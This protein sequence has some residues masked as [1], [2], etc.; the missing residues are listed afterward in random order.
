MN[1]MRVASIVILSLVASRT[2][3]QDSVVPIVGGQLPQ[4]LPVKVVD[5]NGNPIKG[6]EVSPWAL[7]SSQGHG[8]WANNGNDPSE[9]NPAAVT[10]NSDGIAKVIY[11]F[12]RDV[13]EQTRTT[14]VSLFLKH[15]EYSIEDSVHLDVPIA[16]DTPEIIQM[17]LSASIRFLPT[18]DG[19]P[20]RPSEIQV[21]RSD[22]SSFTD[23]YARHI[24]DEHVIVRRLAPEQCDF[25][26]VR[27]VDEQPTHFSEI[28]TVDL[29]SGANDPQVVELAPSTSLSG[30]I[31]DQVPRPIREGRVLAMTVP[32][33]SNRNRLTWSTWG[34]IRTDGTFEIPHWPKGETMQLIGLT[35][36][37]RIRS[38]MV[39]AQGRKLPNQAAPAE[40]SPVVI[41]PPFTHPIELDTEQLHRCEIRLVD[42][43][44]RPVAGA[45]V[46]AYPNVYWKNWGSQLYGLPLMQS[47]EFFGNAKLMEEIN[48]QL[49]NPAFPNR[50]MGPVNEEGEVELRL[51]SGEWDL[52][53]ES[54]THALPVILGRRNHK[55]SVGKSQPNST[56]IRLIPIGTDLLGDYDKLAGVVFGCSTR[57][58]QRICALPGVREKM[59]QFVERIQNAKDPNDP[60]ILAEA[61]AFVAEAF[62]NA[63]DPAEAAKWREKSAA[64]KIKAAAK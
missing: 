22:I 13:Q 44:G 32:P 43:D 38:L 54:K 37:H 1:R 35:N 48:E 16:S 64:M 45:K 4:T 5:S 18:I 14:S 12:F 55:I 27:L 59:I 29:Q 17:K 21:M 9:L 30:R 8:R 57:E 23:G 50:F 34:P 7:R 46:A 15:P 60:S 36:G 53:V 10:T 42:L 40:G 58:G 28:F 63:N 26:L 47:T 61:F 56:S 19:N 33:Q 3:G 51:P 31:S 41:D 24:E 52:Y 49:E 20:V 2:A 62:E 11:P 39:D 25:M 6:V